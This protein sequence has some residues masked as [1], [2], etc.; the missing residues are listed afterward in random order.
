MSAANTFGSR[1]RITTF[2]ES[3]GVALGA[4]IDGMPAGVKWNDSLLL[5]ELARRRPGQSNVVTARNEA[6]QPEVLSGVFE[7]KT[8]GT[9]IAVIV[10]NEDQRSGDYK[11]IAK[12]ARRGHADDMWRDKFGVS[13]PRGGGRSSGRETLSRV[14]GGAAAKMMLASLAPK[15]RVLGYARQIGPFEITDEEAALVQKMSFAAKAAKPYAA[16]RFTARFPSAKRHRDV[17]ALLLDA[18]ANGKS[19]GGVAEIVVSGLPRSLGQPVF[20]KLK[21]DLASA[22]LSVG[23]TAGIEIGDG[24]DASVAEGS[25]FHRRG[26]LGQENQYGGLR[27]GISTGEPIVFRVA[28][29][30]TA[31]VLDTAR[32]G[33]HDPCIVPRAIPVLEAM[34]SLVLAD[35]ILWR[36]TDTV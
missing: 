24:F 28:F 2:G 27:G 30:P 14:I 33:R 4:V 15:V 26:S 13:D 10:R 11:K 22:M 9:P 34:T 17:E 35:H 29:K 5:R 25:E 18:K 21:N 6:D 3:H 19:Y 36:R 16:D 31:T 7:G 12:S 32:K 1:F 20:H 8:L 23:A